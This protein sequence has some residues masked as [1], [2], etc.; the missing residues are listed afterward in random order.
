MPNARRTVFRALALATVGLGLSALPASAQAP[1]YDAVVDITYPVTGPTKFTNDYA[2]CRGVNCE[3]RHR[4]TDVMAPY[5][6]SV[7]AAMGGIIT[8]ITGLDDRP[9]SYGY[10]ITIAGDDGRAYSYIHLGRQTGTA[11]EAYASGMRRGL[12]VERGQHIGTNGCSGNASCSAPH[13][14]FEIEDTRVTDPYG[15]SRINPFSSL[16]S[17][18]SR[19]DYPIQVSS[20]DTCA[21]RSYALSGDWT[22]AGRDAPGWWC[23]GTTRLLL[24]NGRVEEFT[25]GR[26]GDVPIVADWNASGS[27]TVSVIRDGTWH[28]NNSL[29]GGPSTKQFTY[30]RVTQG[31]VPISGAWDRA[32]ASMPGIIRDGQWHLKSAQSGGGADVV[33]TYGRLSRG[34][35]PLVGDWNGDGRSRIGIVRDGE[36]HLRDSLGGGPADLAFT[37]GRVQSGDQPVVGDWNGDGRSTPGIVRSGDW[38]LRY[39]NSRGSANTVVR[40]PAP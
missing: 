13:L 12:R 36:W 23:D 32:G 37:Y 14:H 31:D 11:A 17:A 38:H 18:Q 29:R 30:G 20:I 6:A 1:T 39:S 25:Y 9:P 16:Q 4:A 21:G 34:D 24:G 33:F 2:A 5:G 35:L 15:T 22:G 19:N 26:T 7:H 27:E 40:F 8:F 3:R 28:L 10:M